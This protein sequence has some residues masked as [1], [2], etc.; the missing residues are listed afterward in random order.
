MNEKVRN[1]FR[2]ID[3]LYGFY[4]LCHA[5][6]QAHMCLIAGRC[7]RVTIQVS[8]DGF[9]LRLICMFVGCDMPIQLVLSSEYNDYNRL[10]GK[11]VSSCTDSRHALQNM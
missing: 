6:G 4:L 3:E 5:N 11:I 10:E 8:K 2:G 9:M 1:R 7:C